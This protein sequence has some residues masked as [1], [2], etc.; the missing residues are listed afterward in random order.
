MTRVFDAPRHLVFEAFTKV[1][2]VRRWWC[3]MEGYTMPVCEI[4][5]RVG[6]S[7]RY[8]MRATDGTEHAFKG[9][10]REIVKPERIVHTEIYDVEP[11]NTEAAVITMT[12]EERDG[13][14]YYTSLTRHETKAGRDAHIAS[15]MEYGVNI[16]FE[17]LET[18][19]RELAASPTSRGAVKSSVDANV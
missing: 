10:Y 12:L 18:V 17:R 8:V 19:A 4:D 14:T 1:E 5:L 15:G 11:Y 13:K 16:A 3:C 9:V 6:G 7:Y 2:H